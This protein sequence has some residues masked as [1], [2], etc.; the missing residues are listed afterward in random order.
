[1]SYEFL[2]LAVRGLQIKA[3]ITQLNEKKNIHGKDKQT[4]PPNNKFIYHWF[5]RESKE[6]LKMFGNGWHLFCLAQTA[7]HKGQWGLIKQRRKRLS[8]IKPSSADI[9]F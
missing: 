3:N 2:L 5:P 1:M 8:P 7:V 4:N 9:S 6:S